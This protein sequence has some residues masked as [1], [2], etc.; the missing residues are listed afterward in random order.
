MALKTY[1]GEVPMSPKIIPRLI[2]KPAELSL[3]KLLD[4]SKTFIIFPA[5]VGIPK[6][7][8]IVICWDLRKQ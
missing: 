8:T 5:N 4:F 3:C 7:Y 1:S 2:N 6:T